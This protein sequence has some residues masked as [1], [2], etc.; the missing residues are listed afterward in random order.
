MNSYSKSLAKLA[1]LAGPSLGQQACRLGGSLG[2]LLALKNGF[3]AFESALHVFPHA[4]DAPSIT[5]DRWNAETLWKNEYGPLVQGL[6]FF[7]EDIFGNQ[8]GLSGEM[9]CFF[10]AET[11]QTEKIA[12]C[13]GEWAEIILKDYEQ[14]TSYPVAH[15]W[16]KQF[17]PIKASS[18]LMLKQPLALGGNYDLKNVFEVD[19]VEGMK[20]RG[21]IALQIKDLPDGTQIEFYGSP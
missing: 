10:D 12:D 15:W 2:D 21:H 17:G 6:F 20:L 4:A 7:A 1:S 5:L 19:R 11:G 9:V 8:F 16:Q 13:V 14:L 18:R 3:F